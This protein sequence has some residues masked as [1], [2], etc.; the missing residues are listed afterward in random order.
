MDG[1]LI[2]AKEWHYEAL[3]R[4]LSLFGCPIS[5]LDHIQNFDGLPTVKKLELL[6][7]DRGL[8]QQLHEFINE[9][10]QVYTM[11]IIYT[12]CKPTFMHEYALSKLSGLNYHIA[13][14]SNSVRKSVKTMMELAA[15]DKYIDIIFSNEDVKH[16]KP[17]P[18]MYLK[19][20]QFFAVEPNECLIIEDNENGIKAAKASGGHLLKVEG[21]CDVN[22]TNIMSAILRVNAGDKL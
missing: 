12:Q 1:V 5:R 17:D 2:E 11:E 10:K 18:E 19:A 15:L 8:P 6:S 7:L 3:N 22:L 14:C 20:M 16:S 4:A 21:I 13:V 9:M